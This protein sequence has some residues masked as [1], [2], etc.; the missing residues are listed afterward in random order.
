M[1]VS[2]VTYLLLGFVLVAAFA[3]VLS[4][5]AMLFIVADET[6]VLPEPLESQQS[7]GQFQGRLER[8]GLLAL[9]DG[10]TTGGH[11]SASAA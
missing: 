7:A 2:A 11:A 8:G 3:L 5:L 1:G 10:R 9:T 4:T 6:S